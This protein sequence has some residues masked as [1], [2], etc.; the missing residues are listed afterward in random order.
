MASLPDIKTQVFIACLLLIY[1]LNDFWP[2]HWLLSLIGKWF[3]IVFGSWQLAS[4]LTNNFIRPRMAKLRPENKI[5]LITGKY[6]T[7]M[8]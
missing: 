3:M 2:L 6:Y 8:F 5:V 7:R 4:L 1:F